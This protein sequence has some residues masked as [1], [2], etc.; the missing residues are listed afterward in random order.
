MNMNT[1]RSITSGSK[2]MCFKTCRLVQLRTFKIYHTSYDIVVVLIQSF[3]VLTKV[4]PIK[5]QLMNDR[6]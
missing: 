4:V 5:F 3:F 1:D 2:R 6:H